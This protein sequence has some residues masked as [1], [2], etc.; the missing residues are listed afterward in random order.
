[1]VWNVGSGQ[2]RKRQ[3]QMTIR[4]GNGEMGECEKYLPQRILWFVLAEGMTSWLC[5]YVFVSA[6]TGSPSW[7]VQDTGQETEMSSGWDPRRFSKKWGGKTWRRALPQNWSSTRW[8]SDSRSTPKGEIS[9]KSLCWCSTFNFLLFNLSEVGYSPLLN[10]LL[11]SFFLH[12]KWVWDG[13]FCCCFEWISEEVDSGGLKEKKLSNFVL[14]EINTIYLT[15]FLNS[16]PENV[17]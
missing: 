7:G 17:F 12:P 8:T 4:G 10:V 6:Q 1:M 2:H 14:K 9:V 13:F 11:R 15:C 3:K 5:Y 16:S